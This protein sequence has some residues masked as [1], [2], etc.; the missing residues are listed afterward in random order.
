MHYWTPV[1]TPVIIPYVGSH[2][3]VTTYGSLAADGRQ[4]FRTYD[5]LN[6]VTFVEY[7]KSL[8]RCFGKIVVIVDRAALSKS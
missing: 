8:Y 1:G 6:A 5:R 2:D 3:A 7:L 4:F